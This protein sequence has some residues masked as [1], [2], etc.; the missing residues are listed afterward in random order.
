MV[1]A[2]TRCRKVSWQMLIEWI[3]LH[4]LLGVSEVFVYQKDTTPEVNRVF[5]SYQQN[6]SDSVR[7]S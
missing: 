4:A 1:T 5:E 7:V 6:R 3:E 2:V